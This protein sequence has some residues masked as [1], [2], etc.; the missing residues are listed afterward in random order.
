VTVVR[1]ALVIHPGAL[2]DVL[3]ALPALEHLGRLGAGVHRTLAA[4]ARLGGLLAGT[5]GVE[6]ALDLEG[7]GLHQLF[8]AEPD[9]GIIR[10][11]ADYDLVVSW[12]G[13]GDPTYT[14]HLGRLGRPVVVARSM[15]SLAAGR[16]ASWHLLDTLAALGPGPRAL[17]EVRLAPAPDDRRWARAWLN[18]HELGPA[19]AVVLHPGAG[20]P[21][22]VW[23]GF[24]ALARRLT[25]AGVRIVAITGPADA[26]ATAR[27]IAAGAGV[28][29]A[30]DLPL[31]RL[32]GLL[33]EARAFVGN[34]S[35]PTHLAA[36]LGCPTLALFGPTDPAVWGPVGSAVTVLAGAGA[37]RERA[38]D[39]GAPAPRRPEARECASDPWA[40]VDVAA[41][42]ARVEA[43]VADIPAGAG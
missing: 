5:G 36:A 12:L 43:V 6:A 19:E 21:A 40:G 26:G 15:P 35:G 29:V 30:P 37:V 31:G 17:P 23:P 38:P 4:G 39:G 42:A 18:A 16:H 1:R 10:M 13:A 33:A 25:A 32:A 34:D 9:P 2:G 3:L 14:G 24:P 28:A 20:R 7:L 11:L 41:V 22:K 27:E 8:L